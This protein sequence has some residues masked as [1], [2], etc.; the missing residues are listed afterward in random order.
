[1]QKIYFENKPTN[2]YKRFWKIYYTWGSCFELR[3]VYE[4]ERK[5]LNMQLKNGTRSNC[6]Y[7]VCL[8]IAE[9]WNLF[10]YWLDIDIESSTSTNYQLAFELWTL[11]LGENK[12]EI[13][14]SRHLKVRIYSVH[15]FIATNFSPKPQFVP[16][17]QKIDPDCIIYIEMYR[18]RSVKVI[19]RLHQLRT[20]VTWWNHIGR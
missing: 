13:R 17:V 5:Y 3:L 9:N 2:K 7:N 11:G 19:D 15:F 18:I 16:N 6:V 10:Y 4:Y 12:H 20:N 1:M 14:A 8:L